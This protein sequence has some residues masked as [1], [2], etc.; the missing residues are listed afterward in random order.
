[1]MVCIIV[2]IV[3]ILYRQFIVRPEL[4]KWFSD[5][6]TIAG[7]VVSLSGISLQCFDLLR[8]RLVTHY[9]TYIIITSIDHIIVTGH[10]INTT[11][12]YHYFMSYY[13]TIISLQ[14]LPFHASISFM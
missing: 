3:T 2:M 13:Y 5:R 7:V 6:L 9:R 12:I 14:P 8:V 4:L 11:I 10:T 1:M